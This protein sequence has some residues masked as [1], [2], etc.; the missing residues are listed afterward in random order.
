MAYNLEAPWLAVHVE[1]AHKLSDAEHAQLARNLELVRSLG[2]EVIIT[3]G[4]DV[5]AAIVHVARQRNATQ[6]VAGKP[7]PL[8]WW[9]AGPRQALVNNLI[10]ISGDIDIYVVSGEDEVAPPCG[11]PCPPT[12]HLH[13][14]QVICGRRLL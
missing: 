7:T 8:P 10:H 2:G 6:I 9:R 13:N 11:Q 14:G 4:S 5:A 12:Q 1:T 3:A